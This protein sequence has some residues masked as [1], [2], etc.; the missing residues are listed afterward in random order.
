[1]GN[2]LLKGYD[3]VGDP[4]PGMGS[5]KMWKV[6]HGTRKSTNSKVSIFAI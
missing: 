3:I 6:F 2:Q 5:N 4:T 1:M